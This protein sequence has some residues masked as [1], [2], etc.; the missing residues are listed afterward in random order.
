MLSLGFY[1]CDSSS[2]VV[3]VLSVPYRSSSYC[4]AKIRLWSGN[5]LVEQKSYKLW[6]KNI[7]HWRRV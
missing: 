5:V 4:K 6:F 3:E 1:K 2:L 7:K